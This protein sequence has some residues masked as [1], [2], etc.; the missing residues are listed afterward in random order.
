MGNK[1]LLQQR[2][3]RRKLF[4]PATPRAPKPAIA[5]ADPDDLRFVVSRALL[6][7]HAATALR[8]E[9]KHQNLAQ[10]V[11]AGRMGRHSGASISRLLAGD[12][13]M[14]LSTLADIATALGKRVVLTLVDAVP[15][16][17]ENSPE[18]VS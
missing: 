9:A 7:A 14:T 12:V 17:P 18:N 13:N 5:I 15:E 11:F 6:I 16:I 4:A 2:Q 8:D 1:L 10:A 3:P